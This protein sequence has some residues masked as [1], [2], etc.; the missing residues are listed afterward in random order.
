[1]GG[2][3][4]LEKMAMFESKGEDNEEE[5]NNGPRHESL[6]G[7]KR[8]N[9]VFL[10][11]KDRR[12]TFLS[13]SL[14]FHKSKKT[15]KRGMISRCIVFWKTQFNCRFSSVSES[16]FLFFSSPSLSLFL[17]LSLPHSDDGDDEDPFSAALTQDVTRNPRNW[18]DK[19]V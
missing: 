12:T 17:S 3:E 18:R 2:D 8:I 14:L 13:N 5:E 15:K 16:D 1:M 11:K 19:M 7:K 9:I 6:Q 10:R 4:G